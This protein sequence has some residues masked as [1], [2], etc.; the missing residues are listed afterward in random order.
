MEQLSLLEMRDFGRT[1]V[2]LA[3]YANSKKLKSMG[4]CEQDNVI[5]VEQMVSMDSRNGIVALPWVS[6]DLTGN[7]NKISEVEGTLPCH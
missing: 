5:E 6:S 3:A 4:G 7:P 2:G 1:K